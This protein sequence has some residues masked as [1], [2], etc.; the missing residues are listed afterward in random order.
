M[1]KSICFSFYF[2]RHASNIADVHSIINI[3]RRQT[4]DTL[5]DFHHTQHHYSFLSSLSSLFFRSFLCLFA[6]STYRQH[7]HLIIIII[8]DTFFSLFFLALFLLHFVL[9]D[10]VHIS[11]FPFLVD[12][13][14]QK[15]FSFL[16]SMHAT[17]VV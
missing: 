13:Y 17:C 6:E 11:S 5:F 15:S 1:C 12:D 14:Y 2:F 3:D 4:E 9:P 16:F 7:R 10:C 8:F